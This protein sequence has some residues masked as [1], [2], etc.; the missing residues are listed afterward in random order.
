[1]LLNNLIIITVNSLYDKLPA[2]ILSSSSPVESSL[3]CIWGLFLCFHFGC[4]FEFVCVLGGS[5]KTLVQTHVRSSLS[6]DLGFRFGVSGIDSLWLPVL[7]LCVCRKNQAVHQGRILT[8]A[9]M[10]DGQLK[11]Q[12]SHRSALA[13]RLD[14]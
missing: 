3:S 2:L 13:A 6:L 7:G 1:M 4:F 9:G 10:G 12:S 11:S 14:H 8:T 5:A